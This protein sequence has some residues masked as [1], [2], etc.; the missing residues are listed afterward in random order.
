M[1]FITIPPV[2]LFFCPYSVEALSA[3]TNLGVNFIWHDDMIV[4][5]GGF[6]SNQILLLKKLENNFFIRAALLGS[7]ISQIFLRLGS[8]E[9]F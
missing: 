8:V 1:I 4:R 2:L 7:N 5:G 3:L 9:I 6:W